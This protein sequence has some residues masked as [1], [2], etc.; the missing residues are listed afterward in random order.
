M[1]EAPHLFLPPIQGCTVRSRSYNNY[2]TPAFRRD[3][4]S[5]KRAPRR[6]YPVADTSSLL[7]RVYPTEYLDRV[8]NSVGNLQRIVRPS[9]IRR[10]DSAGRE[11]MPVA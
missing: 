2:N 9:R 5:H 3:N 6:L 4:N 8:H 7:L 10:R 11:G 1:V